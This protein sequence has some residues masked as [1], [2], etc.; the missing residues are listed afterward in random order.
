MDFIDVVDES[1]DRNSSDYQKV[2][3]SITDESWIETNSGSYLVFEKGKSFKYYQSFAD[4]S[5]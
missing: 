4:T 2:V 5:D 1:S 3:K